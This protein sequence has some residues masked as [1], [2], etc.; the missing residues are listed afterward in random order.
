MTSPEIFAREVVVKLENGLHLGPASRVVQL[1]QGFVCEFKIH[2]GE[3]VV[4]AKS[5]LDLLTLM[6]E[7]GVVLRL[8]AAGPDAPQAVDAVARLFELNFPAD[9]AG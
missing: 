1:A 6:A 8:E 7:Q 2:K 5:M 9:E 3:K 4:N